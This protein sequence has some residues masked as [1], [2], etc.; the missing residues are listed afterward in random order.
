[1]TAHG[2]VINFKSEPPPETREW[3]CWLGVLA[4]AP[5]GLT[6]SKKFSPR[7]QPPKFLALFRATRHHPRL[8]FIANKRRSHKTLHTCDSLPVAARAAIGI[9]CA[10]HTPLFALSLTPHWVRI[11]WIPLL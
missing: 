1:L 3:T 11:F 4:A 10:P 6:P 2:R 7:P 8:E 5:P 9:P